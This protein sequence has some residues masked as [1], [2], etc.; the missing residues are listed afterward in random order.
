MDYSFDDLVAIYQRYAKLKEWN[1]TECVAREKVEGWVDMKL[2]P[3]GL[4]IAYHETGKDNADQH[5][6]YCILECEFCGYVVVRRINDGGGC[7]GCGG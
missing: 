5:K 2:G 6:A 4:A 7:G 3:V 1:T